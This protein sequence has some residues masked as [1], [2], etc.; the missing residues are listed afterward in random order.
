MGRRIV[1]GQCRFVPRIAGLISQAIDRESAVRHQSGE[2]G[3]TG[4]DGEGELRTINSPP[5]KTRQI[6]GELAFPV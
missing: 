4:C 5:G 3:I 6:K 1:G 2:T